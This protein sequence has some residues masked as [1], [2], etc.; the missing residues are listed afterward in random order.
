MELLE[1]VGGKV[2]PLKFM[3]R[4]FLGSWEVCSEARNPE[5]PDRPGA[6]FV[7]TKPGMAIAPLGGTNGT[8]DPGREPGAL[9]TVDAALEGAS[10]LRKP[11]A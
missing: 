4:H 2:E 7:G 5:G 9:G 1:A 10:I 8:A 3:G 11:L 6:T